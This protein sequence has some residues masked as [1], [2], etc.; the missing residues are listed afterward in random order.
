MNPYPHLY[1]FVSL[2]VVLA[3][4]AGGCQTATQKT[5]TPP[6]ETPN[7]DG[8]PVPEAVS[9]QPAPTATPTYLV[10]PDQL[11]GLTIRF[12][13]PWIGG[14]ADAMDELAAEFNRTN[15]WGIVVEV[16]SAGSSMALADLIENGGDDDGKPQVVI[17]P[18]EHLLSWLERGSLIRPLN[19][20][21]ADPIFGLSEQQRVDF[22]LVYWQQD[23][24]NGVQAG[25]P[26]QRDAPVIYYNQTWA[27]ELGF[28]SPPATMDTFKQQT[29]AAADAINHDPFYANNGTGGWIVNTD[30]LVVYS[31]LLAFGLEDALSGDP[32][33]FHFNQPA[34]Q[35]AFT[36]FRSLFDEGCIWFARST[37]S[38]EYFANR[39]A[40]MYT[41]NLSDLALQ[42]K[43][44]ARVESTDEWTIL[45]FP[46][47]AQPVVVA[48]GLSF[49]VLNSTPDQELAAWLFVRWMSQPASNSRILLAGGG[50]PVN[51]AAARLVDHEIQNS[52]LWS[53][54]VRWASTAQPAPP[55]S[56]WRI[57]RFVL[58]DAFWQSLQSFTKIEDFPLILEQID[59]T[60]AEVESIR[61][62]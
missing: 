31:W 56:T 32:L 35:Q 8:T 60:I 27:A 54:A 40:L 7:V 17:A 55:V 16:S 36:Y 12:T 46:S 21:I 13:H 34:T 2:F 47:G 20:L 5:Q 23:Q 18:S 58:Q 41:G 1:R 6:A 28:T 24:S 3:L 9:T 49:G 15:E 52:P 22:P 37:A 14:L 19:D 53:E 39:E 42:T 11:Q 30:G 44:Q 62:Y 33:A 25:I 10:P 29:C 4:L 61:G 45:P 59:A 38:N 57:A 51:D 26:V 50:L 43:T 48:S